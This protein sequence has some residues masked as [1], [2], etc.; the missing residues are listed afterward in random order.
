MYFAGAFRLRIQQELG[1]IVGQ[2]L[3]H[4]FGQDFCYNK[5]SVDSE[6]LL[7]DYAYSVSSDVRARGII[8]TPKSLTKGKGNL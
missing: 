6:L 7:R 8:G 3:E 2:D 4:A 5:N 1:G